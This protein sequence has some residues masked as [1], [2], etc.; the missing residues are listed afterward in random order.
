MGLFLTLRYAFLV[1]TVV[2]GLFKISQSNVIDMAAGNVTVCVNATGMSTKCET[3]EDCRNATIPQ[4]DF[5]GFKAPADSV[6]RTGCTCYRFGNHQSLC[7]SI[8]PE[9]DYNL[10]VQYIM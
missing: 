2:H 3:D 7:V 5:R 8:P 9:P 1:L 6:G 4:V 10:D